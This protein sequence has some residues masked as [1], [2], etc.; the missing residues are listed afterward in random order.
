MVIHFT[1]ISEKAVDL[2]E[3]QNKLVFIVDKDATKE[4]IKKAVEEL[5]KVKVI[6]VNTS[7]NIKGRKRA[8]VKL[9][10]ENP[11]TEIATKLNII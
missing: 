5:Y 11:A 3:K 7:T 8:F 6:K 10:K 9:S 2:I 4:E 1:L